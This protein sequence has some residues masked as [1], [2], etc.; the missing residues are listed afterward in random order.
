[1]NNSYGHDIIFSFAINARLLLLDHIISNYSRAIS[2]LDMYQHLCNYVTHSMNG[3]YNARY[4]WFITHSF[5][6]HYS[7]PYTMTVRFVYLNYTSPLIANMAR[8]HTISQPKESS[9]PTFTRGQI[10]ICNTQLQSPSNRVRQLYRPCK[11]T[12]NVRSCANNH[13][14]I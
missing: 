8:M 2:W 6:V 12:G 1:M 10:Q 9:L 14:H 7:M 4:E 5:K 11:S 13:V 3:I